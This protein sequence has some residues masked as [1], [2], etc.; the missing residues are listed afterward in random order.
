MRALRSRMAT[1]L[2]SAIETL[3]TLIESLEEAPEEEEE[4]KVTYLAR[5]GR[6]QQAE[7]SGGV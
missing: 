7:S 3:L 2:R 6:A 1:A 5:S 4:S